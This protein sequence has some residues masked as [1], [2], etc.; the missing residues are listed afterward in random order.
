MKR[1]FSRLLVALLQAFDLRLAQ[2]RM[3][4]GHAKA[5]ILCTL[6]RTEEVLSGGC[7]RL[8]HGRL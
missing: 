7:S 8:M 5:L 6:E 4:E 3:P 2:Q 1:N